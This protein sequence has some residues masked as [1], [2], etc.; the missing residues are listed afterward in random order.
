MNTVV[1]GQRRTCGWQVSEYIY[2]D[3][4][5]YRNYRDGVPMSV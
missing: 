2:F 5:G 4:S 3:R 1:A